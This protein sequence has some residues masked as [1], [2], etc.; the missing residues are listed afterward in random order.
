MG[1]VSAPQA[2]IAGADFTALFARQPGAVSGVI[3]GGTGCNDY[4]ATYTG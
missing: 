2:P 4:N 3:V 1:P